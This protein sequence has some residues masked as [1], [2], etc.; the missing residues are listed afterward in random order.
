M[1]LLT[2][3]FERT[4]RHI[5]LHTPLTIIVSDTAIS[6]ASKFDQRGDAE[7]DC[8]VMVE[9]LEQVFDLECVPM[10][11]SQWNRETGMYNSISRLMTRHLGAAETGDQ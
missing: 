5:F 1:Y 8:S 3:A 11:R 7:M 2:V 4:I 10:P 9:K 6:Q